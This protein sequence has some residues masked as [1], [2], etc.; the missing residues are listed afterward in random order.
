MVALKMNKRFIGYSALM[1]IMGMFMVPLLL[2][3]ILDFGYLSGQ[4]W[5]VSVIAPQIQATILL[6]ALPFG[7]LM[8]IWL[9]K[10]GG[11]TYLENWNMGRKLRVVGFL[12]L[13]GFMM[14][15]ALIIIDMRYVAYGVS[16][17]VLENPIY[18][19]LLWTSCALILS[20]IIVFI[21]LWII[22]SKNSH[23]HPNI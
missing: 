17:S 11:S 18:L 8:Y 13:S 9:E 2:T 22:H 20:G 3:V 16:P 19:G 10:G 1:F 6:E 21:G 7:V 12:P 14:N 23:E 15:V 4:H 5:G